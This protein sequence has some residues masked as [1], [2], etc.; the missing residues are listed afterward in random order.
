MTI[1]IRLVFFFFVSILLLKTKKNKEIKFFREQRWS[2]KDILPTYLIF[3]LMP[4]TVFLLYETNFLRVYYSAFW[5]IFTLL[6][7]IILFVSVIK[8]IVRKGNLSVK[9]I[10]FELSDIYLFT[11]CNI[12]IYSIIIFVLASKR[13]EQFN[14]VIFLM[15]NAFMI[16]TFWPIVEDVFYLGMMLIPTSRITGLKCGA[17]L[18]SL[19]SVLAHYHYGIANIVMNF[20]IVLFTCYLYVRTEKIIFPIMFHSLINSFVLLRDLV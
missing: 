19:S 10:G 9:V 4:L 20:L 2:S 12:I 13:P 3:T 1:A 17:I 11:I 7:G 5:Y 18:V 8:I 14:N 6:T 15:L 16:I